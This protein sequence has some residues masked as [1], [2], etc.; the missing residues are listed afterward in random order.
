MT[1]KENEDLISC[2]RSRCEERP[3]QTGI[4]PIPSTRGICRCHEGRLL[5]VEVVIGGDPSSGD[6][7]TGKG[8]QPL[9][10]GGIMK[11]TFIQIALALLW[12]GTWLGCASQT[13]LDRNWGRSFESAKHRQILVPEAGSNPNPVHGMIGPAGERTLQG[14]ITGGKTPRP[15]PSEITIKP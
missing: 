14:Y 3:A 7:D 9:N 5:S 4:A 2:P 13:E 1:H 11:R 10:Q 15:Y 6:P 12:G 8:D